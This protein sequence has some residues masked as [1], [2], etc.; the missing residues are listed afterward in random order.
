MQIELNTKLK[1]QGWDLL[2]ETTIYSKTDF[3]TYSMSNDLVMEIHP[4]VEKQQKLNQFKNPEMYSGFNPWS[5]KY[6]YF[7]TIKEAC[8]FA[9]EKS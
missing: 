3:N 9:T 2:N 7:Y 5:G 1:N 8:R 4:R 6:G